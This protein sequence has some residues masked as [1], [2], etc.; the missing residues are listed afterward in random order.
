[1]PASV[2]YHGAIGIERAV[3]AE[4]V[5]AHHVVVRL[6]VAV[7]VDGQVE[8]HG[9]VI[10]PPELRLLV[11]H[12]RVS[13]AVKMMPRLPV[14]AAKEVRAEIDDADARRFHRRIG[15]RRIRLPD[16][17]LAGGKLTSHAGQTYQDRA[18]ESEHVASHSIKSPR[19][20]PTSSSA[21]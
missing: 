8:S 1:M 4:F 17:A 10:G 18:C 16:L 2:S 11:L 3:Q 20:L 21:E 14:T 12:E 9:P 19:E 15:R 13:V 7:H 5:I 6:A